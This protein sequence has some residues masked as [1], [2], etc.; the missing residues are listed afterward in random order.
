MGDLKQKIGILGYGEVG[1][2]IAKFYKKPL[3]KDLKRD[4]N[5][6]NSDILN[7]CIPYSKNFVKI[8]RE[9]IKFSKPELT[10]IH[11]TV[12]PGTKKKLATQ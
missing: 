4:D 3:I 12:A 1:K 9:Q 10:I 11:S 7:I 2:A 5:L 6:E 8:V